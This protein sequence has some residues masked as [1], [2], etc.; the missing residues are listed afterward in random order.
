MLIT[1]TDPQTFIQVLFDCLLFC[2]SWAF[3]WDHGKPLSNGKLSSYDYVHGL[4]ILL[5]SA[6]LGTLNLVR[7]AKEN[8]LVD[9]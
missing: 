4:D 1:L 3:D 5:M 2:H 7:S 6:L 9:S 8:L